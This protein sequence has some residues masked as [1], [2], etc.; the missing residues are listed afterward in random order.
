MVDRVYFV[1]KRRNK[2]EYLFDTP[3]LLAK[4]SRNNDDIVCMAYTK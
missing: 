3:K 1:A 2:G 4:A